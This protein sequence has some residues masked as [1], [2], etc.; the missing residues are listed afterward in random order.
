[1]WKCRNY[2]GAVEWSLTDVLE[3]IASVEVAFRSWK[4]I[5][6]EPAAQDFL[7]RLLLKER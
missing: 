6:E 2:D 7:V 5:R 4:Q 3:K 1:L